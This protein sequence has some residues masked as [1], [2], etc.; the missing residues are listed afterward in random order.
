[1][2]AFV[3]AGFNLI[4]TADSYS[5]WVPGN[6][7]GESETVIGRWLSQRPGARAKVLIATKVGSEMGP[8]ESGLSK[9]YILREVE[10]WLERLN[11]NYI[12]LYQSH[13]DDDKTPVDE[14]LEAYAQLV[15]QGKIRVIGASNFTVARLEDSL[16]S[17][18]AHGYARYE[19]LQPEYNLYSR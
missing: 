14:T 16:R 3:A 18:A 13:R 7:G 2:D 11:T 9:S 19:S 15:R 10:R 17:S 8:G 12:D 4:D 5:R 6:R 1:L